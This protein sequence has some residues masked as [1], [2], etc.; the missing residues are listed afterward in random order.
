MVK[1][2][3]PVNANKAGFK[4]WHMVIVWLYSIQIDPTICGTPFLSLIIT[5]D[6]IVFLLNA[7]FFWE[8]VKEILKTFKRS[9]K[10]FPFA[11]NARAPL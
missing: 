10:Q 11:L 9:Q 8:M 7:S 1:L 3:A 4:E 6:G 5:K 2:L